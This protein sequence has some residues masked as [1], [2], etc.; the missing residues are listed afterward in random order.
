MSTRGMRADCVVVGIGLN[1]NTAAF[2]LELPHATSLRCARGGAAFDRADVVA[3]LFA[4]LEERVDRFVAEPT[5]LL[6]EAWRSRSHIFG[7]RVRVSAEGG[8]LEGIAHG[9]DD[10]GALVLETDAGAR[11]RVIAGEVVPA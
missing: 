8:V 7:Q 6:A 9:L 5:R 4:A 1:V 11:V 10:D 2:P 3:R